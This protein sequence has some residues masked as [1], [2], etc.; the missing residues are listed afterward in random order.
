MC[1]CSVWGE[2]GAVSVRVGELM[3]R[4]QRPPKPQGA[5]SSCSLSAVSPLEA[6][7]LLVALPQGLGMTEQSLPGELPTPWPVGFG[8]G[9]KEERGCPETDPESVVR[10]PTANLGAGGTGDTGMERENAS[11]KGKQLIRDVD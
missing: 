8:D 11:G 1:L 10:V 5:S 3:P 2:A 7:L 4:H 9:R 6:Q